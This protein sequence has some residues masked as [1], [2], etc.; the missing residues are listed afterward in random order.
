MAKYDGRRSLGEACSETINADGCACVC[1]CTA[2]PTVRESREQEPR[3]QSL[4]DLTAV[5]RSAAGE[6][7]NRKVT[8]VQGAHPNHCDGLGNPQHV[9]DE[10][11]GVHFVNWSGRSC[12]IVGKQ[13]GCAVELTSS[14]PSSGCA[15]L[16]MLVQ[17]LVC[18]SDATHRRV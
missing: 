14:H 11:I 2:T 10:G 4:L 6:T 1:I 8:T 16:L 3:E 15:P 9:L 13:R 12:T 17:R 5:T 18:G 7:S